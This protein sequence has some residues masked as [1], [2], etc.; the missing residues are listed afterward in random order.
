MLYYIHQIHQLEFETTHRGSLKHKI[1]FVVCLENENFM[2]FLC[3]A[4]ECRLLTY[5]C[6][7]L[8]IQINMKSHM[9]T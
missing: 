1:E 2:L 3:M 6:D 7:F 5:L 4:L 9:F 8:Y